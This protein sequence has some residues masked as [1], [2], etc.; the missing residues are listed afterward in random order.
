ME[1]GDHPG[2]AWPRRLIDQ[3]DG[4]GPEVC[5]RR[6][7]IVSLEAEVVKPFASL[8]QELLDAGSGDD[9][10]QELDLAL[11]RGQESRAHALVPDLRLPDQRKPQ[12]VPIKPVGLVQFFDHDS[13]MVNLPHWDAAHRF[14]G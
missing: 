8:L 13:D 3:G 4:A 2:E 14:S 12:R 11:P 7:H 9:G 10:L 6:G 5:Q 1:E